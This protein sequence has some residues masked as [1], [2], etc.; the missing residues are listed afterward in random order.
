MGIGAVVRVRA[1]FLTMRI[2]FSLDFEVTRSPK[3]D[4]ETALVSQVERGPSF[5]VGFSLPDTDQGD[6]TMSLHGEV[7]NLTPFVFDDPESGPGEEFVQRDKVLAIL[8]RHPE[9]AVSGPTAE[10]VLTIAEGLRKRFAVSNG[11]QVWVEFQ[12]SVESLADEIADI[13][14]QVQVQAPVGE[15]LDGGVS[16]REQSVLDALVCEAYER[17]MDP[18]DAAAFFI[19]NGFHLVTPQANQ[20]EALAALMPPVGYSDAARY[21]TVY[22]AATAILDL[23]KRGA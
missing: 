6:P 1:S 18:S 16:D 14:A 5:P 4:T 19:E 9:P 17:M 13:F 12:G 10:Q 3:D 20:R 21:G 23:L 22:D 11:T 2:R 7:S 15:G 8:A